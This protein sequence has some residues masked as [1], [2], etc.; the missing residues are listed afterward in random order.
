MQAPYVPGAPNAW[1]AKHKYHGIPVNRNI[2]PI[3][4]CK[5]RHCVGAAATVEKAIGVPILT[6]EH[7][8]GSFQVEAETSSW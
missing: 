7:L 3:R 4:E 2:L 1:F 8:W 5:L 6:L